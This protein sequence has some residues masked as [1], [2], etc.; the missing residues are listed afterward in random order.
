MKA[1]PM[2]SGL[3]RPE[4]ATNWDDF[5]ERIA[6]ERCVTSA[7][8]KSYPPTFW[9]SVGALLLVVSLVLLSYATG[10]HGRWWEWVAAAVPLAVLWRMATAA[11][12]RAGQDD[13]RLAE[14]D[15][16]E[17]GWKSHLERVGR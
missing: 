1:M 14:L 7:R 15:L 16:L 17:L 5:L 12:R 2:A 6:V 3:L 11:L 13:K 10:R 4:D 9:V 8:R